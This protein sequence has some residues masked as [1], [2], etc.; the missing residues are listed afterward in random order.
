MGGRLMSIVGI[1]ALLGIAWLLSNNKR[2]INFRTVFVGLGIQF[3]FGVLLLWWE[4]GRDAFQSFSSLVASFLSLSDKGAGFLFGNLASSQYYF[5]DGSYWPGFGFQ[6]A[7]KVLPTIV[8]FS[9]FMAIMYYLGIMQIVIRFLASTMQKLMGTSGSETLSVSAN[10]FVGQTEAPLLIRPFL[11]TMTNSEL[12]TVMVG[13]FATVAGG[14][15]AGYMGMGINP[16]HL[17]VASVL[18]APGAL[19]VGKIIYPETE[20]S[21][22]AGTVKMPDFHMGDNVID[23]AARG[24]TDGLKL[25]VN[26]GAMLLAFISLIAFVDWVMGGLD[27]LIDGKIL[28][29]TVMANGE[30]SGFFPGSLQTFFGTILAPLAFL[31]G[32]PWEDA[33]LIGNLLGIKLAVNEFVGYATLSDYIK[34]TGGVM[35]SERSQI[36]ATYAMCGFANFSSIGIQIGGISALAPNRRGDLA[37]LGLKAMLGGAIASW[38]T[39][40]IAGLLI[41]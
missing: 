34:G 22:T 40:C 28:G 1:F 36:I 11:N 16:G 30:F 20:Q 7:F 39:A 29:G 15:L 19:V 41:A 24:T 21:Q 10:I 9:A 37:R 4:P 38:I 25:A 17:I 14:V 12:M 27:L 5:T 35:I 2:K 31:M 18:S 32:V 6:F 3:T 13:G 8:F 26:V 23:A 33:D